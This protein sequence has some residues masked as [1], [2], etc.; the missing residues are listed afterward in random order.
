MNRLSYAAATASAVSLV[1][2]PSAVAVAS[3]GAA[4]SS[5]QPAIVRLPV[6]TG[7]VGGELLRH[8]GSLFAGH[9]TAPDG[10]HHPALWEQ[11]GTRHFRV[12]ELTLP[13]GV[14]ASS[15]DINAHHDVIVFGRDASGAVYRTYVL[16]HGRRHYLKDFTGGTMGVRGRQINDA[17]EVAGFALDRSGTPWAALWRS[18]NA[19]PTKLLSPPG[20]IDG[21]AL[22]INNRGDVVGNSAVPG[23]TSAHGLLWRHGSTVPVVL[24]GLRSDLALPF[25]INDARRI[26][27]EAGLTGEATVWDGARHPRGLGILPG[28]EESGLLG[29]SDGG[30]AGGWSA[31]YDTGH[32]HLL[33][34]AGHGRAKTLLPLSRHYG[35]DA[36]AYSVSDDGAVGGS[37]DDGSGN[38]QP[39]VWTCADVQA[40]APGVM[41]RRAARG[42]RSFGQASPLTS[43]RRFL[44]PDI[45][46]LPDSPDSGSSS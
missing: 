21:I 35:D 44:R 5:C 37:S 14:V 25:R 6:P 10:N 13:V 2:A 24:P 8:V 38:V 4:T 29:V 16:S 23:G 15:A 28:D 18:W 1:L 12:R 32:F 27:G 36:Q 42:R 7:A 3:A 46:A 33:Y 26:V 19:R 11:T 22:G 43:A 20:D 45:G 41:Q 39:T 17:G 30:R 31:D 40:F 34:W 9:I